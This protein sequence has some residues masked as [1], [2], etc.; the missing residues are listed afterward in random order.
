[1]S[2][3]IKQIMIKKLKTTIR[4]PSV[5][6]SIMLPIIL[7]VVGVVITMIAFPV[8]DDQK[9]SLINTWSKYNTIAFFMSLAF[10]FNTANYIGSIVK[11]REISFTY[12]SYVMG[13]KKSAY[14]IGTIT[15]DM[16]MFCVPFAIIFIA[17]ACFPSD[18]SGPFVSVFGWL[19]LTL[20]L[21]AFAFLPF[22]Y[23]WSFAFEKATSAYRFYPFLVYF[24][25]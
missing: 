16:I 10:A 19:A 7:I 22:T 6:F 2:T 5:F 24:Y 13:M 18:Q 11:E 12:L 20:I 17:I 15:F 4:S 21:F 1:M 9:T 8:S 14:W 3:Q 25:T 23:L